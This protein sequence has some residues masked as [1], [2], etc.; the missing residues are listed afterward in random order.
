MI[1]T[2]PSLLFFFAKM[3]CN[4]W[5]TDTDWTSADTCHW[6]TLLECLSRESRWRTQ[7]CITHHHSD[8]HQNSQSTLQP[9]DHPT[10][11]YTGRLNEKQQ[12]LN[13]LNIL[14]SLSLS[15][16]SMK[17]TN[18]S[19]TVVWLEHLGWPPKSVLLLIVHTSRII[20][21]ALSSV[22]EKCPNIQLNWSS[23]FEM[24]NTFSCKHAIDEAPFSS[25]VCTSSFLSTPTV[26]SHIH[27]LCCRSGVS[28]TGP[29]LSLFTCLHDV[30]EGR[31]F[32][33]L[34][35]IIRLLRSK[36]RHIIQD[37]NQL[38]FVYEA[39][40]FY[41]QD[42]LVKRNISLF[43][44]FFF[45][46]HIP[47]LVCLSLG[48]R[49]CSQRDFDD[50]SA[51]SCFAEIISHP[52]QHC[53]SQRWAADHH[54]SSETTDAIDTQLWCRSDSFID[55]DVDRG[56]RQQTNPQTAQSDRREL[57][58]ASRRKSHSTENNARRLL[59]TSTITS[60]RSLRSIQPTGSSLDVSLI[61]KN[62]RLLFICQ[63]DHSFF[64]FF[65]FFIG[66]F[67]QSRN[68]KLLPINRG[69]E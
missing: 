29:F 18:Q 42:L 54:G 55:T 41:L 40:L 63:Y 43:F 11:S 64:S 32:P 30:E 35:K 48:S 37:M 65:F 34:N 68:I 5:V 44:F 1:N 60:Q 51:T 19:R 24:C 45:Y 49:W 36:R 4:Q 3:K 66:Q 9:Q 31:S 25:L 39:L 52:D 10:S 28:R 7:I 16:P 21:F 27:T 69:S 20:A 33:D 58:S 61:Q 22:A 14:L 13:I 23:S 67:H 57:Q 12:W 59:S 46:R 26:I 38:K 2:W 17:Q 6:C 15:L 62:T 8:Q 47:L 50:A 53:S 56:R